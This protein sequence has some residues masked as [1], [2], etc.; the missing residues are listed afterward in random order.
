MHLTTLVCIVPVSEVHSK[1][2]RNPPMNLYKT[3]SRQKRVYL[4]LPLNYAQ[5]HVAKIDL[6][7]H[8]MWYLGQPNAKACD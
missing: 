5:P 6:L 4:N 2:R 7:S 3:G 8:A 1:A